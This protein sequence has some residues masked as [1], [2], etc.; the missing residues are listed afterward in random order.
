MRRNAR[1]AL[2]RLEAAEA[3]K[4]NRARVTLFVE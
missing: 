4:R 1:R 2:A 3:E